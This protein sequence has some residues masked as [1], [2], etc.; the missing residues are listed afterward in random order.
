MRSWTGSDGEFAHP[1]PAVAVEL[2]ADD[3]GSFGQR[4]RHVGHGLLE[5]AAVDVVPGG[6]VLEGL[7]QDELIGV[8]HAAGPVEP[9]VAGLLTGGPGEIV[10]E[11]E[12]ALGPVGL[13]LE[14]NDDEDH[15]LLPFGATVRCCSIVARGR[16]CGAQQASMAARARSCCCGV[17]TR[18]A[19]CSASWNST[20]ASVQRPA[21]CR[22]QPR[23]LCSATIHRLVRASCTVDAYSRALRVQASACAVS[24][25]ASMCRASTARNSSPR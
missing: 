9:Q 13:D 7:D 17:P 6:V 22:V 20:I 4:L 3:P 2:A 1:V 11:A 25:I 12:P 18:S 19:H 21:S 10:H 16:R 8:V 14:F 24:A 23:L 5:V 15:E